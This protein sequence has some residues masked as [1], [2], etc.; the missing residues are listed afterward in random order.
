MIEDIWMEEDFNKLI[1]YLLQENIEK[2]G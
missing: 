1:E 2:I